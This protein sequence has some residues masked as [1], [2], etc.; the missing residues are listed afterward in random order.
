MGE[1]AR[2]DPTPDESLP[3][4]QRIR[5]PSEFRAVMSTG[6]RGVSRYL[7]SFRVPNGAGGRPGRLG[8]V[9]SR[10]VGGAVS[11]SRAKRLLREVYRRTPVRPTGD[12]VL[13]ARR[14]ICTAPWDRLVRAYQK[15]IRSAGRRQRPGAAG[16]KVTHLGAGARKGPS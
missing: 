6:T 4:A 13:L 16:G 11:R 10:K 7:V 1:Q 2:D 3:K 8:V 14:G 5:R 12:V 9:A 15:A